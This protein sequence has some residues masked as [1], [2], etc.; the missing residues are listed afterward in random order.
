LAALDLRIG[1]EQPFNCLVVQNRQA[2]QSMGRSMD[3]TLQDMV[4]DLFFRATLTGR[5]GG[6]T[7]FVQAGEETSGTSAGAVNP[8]PVCF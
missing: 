2:L 4:D 3:W 6:D 8:D 5:R 1:V 7:S